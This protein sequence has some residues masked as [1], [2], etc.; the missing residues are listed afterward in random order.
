VHALDGEP[1]NDDQVHGRIEQLVSEEHTLWER[2][3]RGEAT[4]D[5]HRRLDEIKVVLDRYWDLLRQRRAYREAG[6][7]V[8]AAHIRDADTV[9]GYQQ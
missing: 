2:E 4:D 5:D 9:E 6:L 1:V 8:D 3:A 7:D